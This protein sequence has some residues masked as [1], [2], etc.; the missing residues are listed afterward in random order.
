[1]LVQL[2]FIIGSDVGSPVCLYQTLFVG[3]LDNI[4]G[5]YY[6]TRLHSA[7]M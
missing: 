5:E 4:L 7:C 3:I 1:M 2:S 6:A